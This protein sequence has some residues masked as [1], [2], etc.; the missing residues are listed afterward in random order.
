MY[1][2]CIYLH[3]MHYQSIFFLFFF[4]QVLIQVTWRA[5][6]AYCRNMVVYYS[7]HIVCCM[8]IIFL[9]ALFTLR[10]FYTKFANTTFLFPMCHAIRRFIERFYFEK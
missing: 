3:A 9:H 5:Q 4:P 2:V 7:E 6:Y 8:Q 10:H 1:T